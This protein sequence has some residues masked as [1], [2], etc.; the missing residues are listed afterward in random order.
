MAYNAA[1]VVA[2]PA[3][4][5]PAPA[6]AIPTNPSSQFHAQDEFANVNY[7]YSNVNSQKHEVGNAYGGVVGSYSY[8]DANGQV[9]KTEYIADALGFRVKAT[10][11]PVAPEFNPEDLPVAPVFDGVAPAPVEKTAEVKAAEAEFFAKFEEEK[12]RTK[13]SVA[14]P[15][16]GAYAYPYATGYPYAAGYAYQGLPYAAA[17]AAPAYAGL[18]PVAAKTPAATVKAVH[19]YT[20]PAVVAA[21]AV[22]AP[23]VAAAPVAYAAPAVAAA[24]AA[25]GVES[26]LTTVKLNPGHAVAY[27]V[28]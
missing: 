9:Q 22:A 28:D 4:V 5:A 18:A 13:R 21:P 19:A 23:A 1:P 24:P 25:A 16:A 3:A 17:Y 8:V 14:L 26:V 10:N 20:A 12:A 6:V 7:G 2:A 27:R 15:Y 11:L